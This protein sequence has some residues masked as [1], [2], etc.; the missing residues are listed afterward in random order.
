MAV[1]GVP[2]YAM[3]IGTSIIMTRMVQRQ[4]QLQQRG[5][6]I[7]RELTPRRKQPLRL[8]RTVRQKNKRKN[9]EVF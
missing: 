1:M 4:Q 7:K 2:K 8:K 6:L 9:F 5:A 3:D